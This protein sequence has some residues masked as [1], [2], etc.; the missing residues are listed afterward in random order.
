MQCQLPEDYVGNS[1][2]EFFGSS[3][4]LR[5]QF[6]LF[7]RH[8][9]IPTF[10]KTQRIRTYIAVGIGVLALITLQT[11][12]AVLSNGYQAGTLTTPVQ[13]GFVVSWF[14]VGQV[15]GLVFGLAGYEDSVGA[16]VF[17]AFEEIEDI[18]AAGVFVFIVFCLAAITPAVGGFVVVGQMIQ[19]FGS[20]ILI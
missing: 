7:G 6:S 10:A 15:L 4:F 8:E 1:E 12:I 5:V 19:Q 17:G 16:T 9:T 13:R 20:C 14:V 2:D 3:E 18:S 11:L